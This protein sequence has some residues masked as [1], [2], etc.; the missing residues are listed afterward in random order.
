MALGRVAVAPIGHPP[1]ALAWIGGPVT[2]PVE[3]SNG[4]AAAPSLAFSSDLALGL[5]RVGINT[6]GIATAGVGRWQV[7]ANG[8]LT[9]ISDNAY[10]IGASGANRP[11]NIYAAGTATIGGATTL[12]GALTYG[13]VTLSNAVTGTGNMVLS[14]SPTLTGTVVLTGTTI[15]GTPTWSS[16]QAITLST[17]AQP[18]VTS[19]GTLTSL[20]TG[21][22][23]ITTTSAATN[24]TLANASDTT[25]LTVV[26]T[27]NSGVSLD[28][29]DG[30]TPRTLTLNA[31]GGTT[32]VQA[33]TAISAVISGTGNGP[34]VDVSTTGDSGALKLS[35]TGVNDSS[36]LVQSDG[37]LG[38]GGF[39]IYSVTDAAYRLRIT[40]TTGLVTLSGALT[41][42]GALSGV[43]TLNCSGNVYTST[44]SAS[45]NSGVATTIF[46][47]STA[48]MYLITTTANETGY[49]AWAM[50]GRDSGGNVTIIASNSGH[51]NFAWGTS[52]ANVQITQSAGSARTINARLLNLLT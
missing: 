12:S 20:L 50:V 17:A 46:T 47:I 16:S 10:D 21:E 52:G 22:T 28:V 8:H 26:V 13:G 1:S 42:A 23:T 33:L 49:I 44:F 35:H 40:G 29:T 2:N 7:D 18:N 9:A 19:V 39:A 15:T 27:A 38:A 36:F 11:R 14:A 31:S 34:H 30:A 37:S 6:L 3:L 51:V 45:A 43:T 48:G 5:Y 24:L 41:I 25:K 4:S 32:A